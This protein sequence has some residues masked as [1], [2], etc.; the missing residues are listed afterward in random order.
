MLSDLKIKSLKPASK[1]KKYA[2][3]EGLFIYLTTTGSKP[4]RRN[5]GSSFIQM[6]VVC[7]QHG[8]KALCCNSN[9]RVKCSC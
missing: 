3:G 8:I 4:C 5:N 9:C 2:D 1:A 7:Y 6:Q